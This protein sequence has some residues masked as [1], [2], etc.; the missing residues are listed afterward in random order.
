MLVAAMVTTTQLSLAGIAAAAFS[1]SGPGS[2]A[3]LAH[4]LAAPTA[5]TAS[6]TSGNS[7]RLDW[8]AQAAPVVTDFLIE[9][10]GNAGVA[11]TT[12]TTITATAETTYTATNTSVNNGTYI[13]RVTARNNDWRKVS[14]NSNS[15]TIRKGNCS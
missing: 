5:V 6:C 11:W 13:Y 3:A 4:A 15:R 2:G 14:A 10:S 9:R 1:A 8:T 12:I 7:I